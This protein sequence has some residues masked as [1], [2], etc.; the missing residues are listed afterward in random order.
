MA[1]WFLA[2]AARTRCSDFVTVSPSVSS[3]AYAG[4]QL[5]DAGKETISL[6]T[7]AIASSSETGS[8]LTGA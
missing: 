1:I 6:R 7:M 4:V 5:T 3:E 2:K 8:C